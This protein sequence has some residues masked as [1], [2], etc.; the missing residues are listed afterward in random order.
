[1]PVIFL[2][3]HAHVY[4]LLVQTLQNQLRN[5]TVLSCGV[6]TL[7]LFSQPPKLLCRNIFTLQNDKVHIRQAIST[8]YCS[9]S[10]HWCP[11]IFYNIL[12]RGSSSLVQYPPLLM[13]GHVIG[14]CKL[15]KY[16]N[17]FHEVLFSCYWTAEIET[18]CMILYMRI[19]KDI[20]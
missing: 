1:M 8:I 4:T 18:I 20:R 2:E 6:V 16:V 19:Y 14:A 11:C 9:K 15:D 13:I 17:S 7:K 10:M 3:Y 12:T 5:N